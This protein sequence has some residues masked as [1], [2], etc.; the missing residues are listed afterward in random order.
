MEKQN[1]LEN[2]ISY[3]VSR[4]YSE[5]DA[6]E[7]YWRIVTNIPYWLDW[8]APIADLVEW[9][10]LS[11]EIKEC[12]FEAG[13][14]INLNGMVFEYVSDNDPVLRE[15]EDEFVLRGD[16][17]WV[18]VGDLSV[19][20]INTDEGVAVDIYATGYEAEQPITSTYAFDTDAQEYDDDD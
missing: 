19:Y 7:V 17:M 10:Q 3:I 15:S 5:E 1:T 9:Y 11:V 12:N 14:Q 16:Y 20:I 18:T 6:E 2:D 13:D 8:D 4:G